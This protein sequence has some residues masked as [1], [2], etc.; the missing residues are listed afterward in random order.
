VIFGYGAITLCGFPFQGNSPNH[1]LPKCSPSKVFQDFLKPRN[2]PDVTFLQPPVSTLP[3]NFFAKCVC[4]IGIHLVGRSASPQDGTRLFAARASR[5]FLEAKLIRGLGLVPFRSPLL[6]ECMELFFKKTVP[7]FFSFPPL[8]GM[9]RF[10]GFA[11]S[12]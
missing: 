10:S 3:P 12:T 2:A 7:S 4:R 8:T 5:S 11:T 1:T 9:F 6:R